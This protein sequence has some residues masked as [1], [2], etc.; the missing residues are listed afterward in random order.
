V[1][2]GTVTGRGAFDT[3]GIAL[4]ARWRLRLRPLARYPRVVMLL[5][6][7]R[8]VR[9]TRSGLAGPVRIVGAGHL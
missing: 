8:M 4:V 7:D 5:N 6:V 1:G 9:R 2:P 3:G